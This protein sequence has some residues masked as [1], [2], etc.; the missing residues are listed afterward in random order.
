MQGE[1]SEWAPFLEALPEFVPS[2]MFWTAQQQEEL[3]RGS[4]VLKEARERAKAL[5]REWCA[6]QQNLSADG[7][8]F[9]TGVPGSYTRI[10][11][12]MQLQ[13]YSTRG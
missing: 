13:Q 2:P 4:P 5:H 8:A 1:K 11:L 7:G 6:I 10:L 9:D 12:Q 3:L